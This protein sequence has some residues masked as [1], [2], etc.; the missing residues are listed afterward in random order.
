MSNARKDFN[1]STILLLY[2]GPQQFGAESLLDANLTGSGLNP[3]TKGLR[4]Q[5]S[6]I[7]EPDTLI[8]YSTYPTTFAIGIPSIAVIVCHLIHRLADTLEMPEMH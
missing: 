8:K 3:P 1:V 2:T 7:R 5:L 4:S 6:F